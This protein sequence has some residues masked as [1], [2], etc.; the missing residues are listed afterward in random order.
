VRRGG[1]LYPC[2]ALGLPPHLKYQNEGGPSLAQCFALVRE[3]SSAPAPDV[4]HLLDAVT[5][6]LL[7]GNNDAHGKNFSFLYDTSGG[8]H[9]IRLA[10]LYDL[11]STA[12]YPELSPK[13]AMKIGSRYTPHQVRLRHW[14][15]WWQAADVSENAAR[16]R[17]LRFAEKVDGLLASQ[18]VENPVQEAIAKGTATRA[19]GLRSS[20]A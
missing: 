2:Q 9:R 18:P 6:N 12:Y 3:I 19:K 8:R 14:Q 17:T 11:V 7:I 10:P 16:K 13:M 1:D 4:L 5:F 15:E 20:L